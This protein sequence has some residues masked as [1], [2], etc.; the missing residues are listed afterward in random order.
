MKILQVLPYFVPAW[1][2]GGPL[3]VCYALSKQLVTRGHEV[4]VYTTDALNAKERVKQREETIDGIKVKRFANLSNTVAYKHHICLSLG[5]LS[6]M[7]E[8][9]SFDVIHMH[10][11]RTLQNTLVHHYAEKYH[12]PYVL[13]AHGSLPR[14]MTKHRLK[15]LY[16]SLGGYRLLRDA[17]RVVALTE[18]EARQY[19]NM[20]VTEG[21]IKIVPNGINPSD[22]DSLPSRGEFRKRYG[23]SD[24]EQIILY[25][26]R[27]HETKGIG[28]LVRAFAGLTKEME[29]VRLVIVGPNDGY[30][31]TLTRLTASVAVSDKVL[32]TGPLYGAG[33]LG[34]YVDADVFVTPSFYGFPV[35]FVEAC[36]CGVPIVTTEKG[37]KL[38]WIHNQAG[39]VVEY[40]ESQL[41]DALAAVLTNRVLAQQFQENGRK[42][43]RQRF[44]WSRIVEG[45]EQIYLEVTAMR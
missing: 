9:R 31:D 10:E 25:L 15:K 27:I 2:Y 28:L 12:V 44:A 19:K 42:L 30:L 40:D 3:Q 20:G 24:N 14:I 41:K 23:L 13:Q 5:M 36:A 16:D 45:L 6:A 26:G 35:T 22:F 29:G 33:K 11:Y 21:K 43:V 32:F 17:A 4:T 8:L 38:D 18:A 7:K 37:D 1:D 34:A 39:Y